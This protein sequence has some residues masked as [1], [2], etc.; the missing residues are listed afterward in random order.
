V[1][2]EEVEQAVGVRLH[3][4]G[5]G[6]PLLA[7]HPGLEGDDLEVVLD[8]HGEEV[9]PPRPGLE[10]FDLERGMRGGHGGKIQCR[11]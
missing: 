6:I 10:R 3:P 1:G 9:K 11:R 4:A 8:I 7:P 5:V 2:G